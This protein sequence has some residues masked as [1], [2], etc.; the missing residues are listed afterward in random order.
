MNNLN[1]TICTILGTALVSCVLPLTFNTKPAAANLVAN[2]SFEQPEIALGSFELLPSIPGWSVD[3]TNA[4]GDIEIQNYVAG[5][6]FDGNQ[7]TELDASGQPRLY[8][9]LPTTVGKSY[10]LQFAFSPRPGVAANILSVNWGNT[11]LNTI[12]ASGVG[13]ADTQ[14]QV[15]SYDLVATTNITR[16]S[17]DNRLEPVDGLGTYLDKVSVNQVPEHSSILGVLIV[18]ALSMTSMLKRKR[19]AKA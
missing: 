10:Q 1:K 6:P 4:F 17:F 2:G 18:S 15:F 14:W 3:Y 5:T 16:L 13:L 7:Y 11:S 8:Q 9:D 19:T 12:S